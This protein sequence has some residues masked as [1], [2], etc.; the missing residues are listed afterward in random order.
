VR[1]SFYRKLL[2]AF[3]AATVVPVVALAIATRSY[4][5]EDMRRSI[6]E[7]AVRTAAAARRVVEDLIAPRATQQ[8][9]GIDDNLMVWVSRLIDQDVNMFRGSQLLATSERNLFASGLLPTWTPADIY[10][11][12]EI[13]AEASAVVREQAGGQEYLVAGT[14]MSARQADAILTVPFTSRQQDIEGRIDTLDRRIL[15]GA[16]LFVFGGAGLGYW[17]AERIADPVSRLMRATRRI[18]RG[19]LDARIEARSSDEFRRLVEDFNRMA[20]ELKRRR[21]ELE[22]S[23]RLEAWAINTVLGGIRRGCAKGVHLCFGNYGGQTIQKGTWGRLLAFCNA[24][25]CDHLVLE[26]A[27]RPDRELRVFRDLKPSIALGVGVIDI[28]DN[29]VESAD[30]VAR[31]IERA[32]RALG[33][34]RLKW[35]HPDCGFWMLPRTVADAKMRALVQGRDLFGA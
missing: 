18:E 9:V 8:D 20:E 2:L 35:V 16:L 29:E 32:V 28:K 26:C 11:A 4:V 27:R 31:R 19:D 3:M 1:A 7:E 21:E 12:V 34:A 5:A 17:L 33:A 30:T 10:R 13:G 22:R 14:P 6:E 25:A 24:L 15:L 23:N